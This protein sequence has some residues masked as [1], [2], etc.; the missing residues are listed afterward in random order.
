MSLTYSTYVT[1]IANLIPTPTSDANFQTVLPNVIDD[2][3]QRIYRE[4]DLL[5]TV[6]ADS[7]SQ[8][9]TGQRVFNLPSSIGTFVV[10]QR[11]N[12]ITPASATSANL[13]TR[14]PLT[15]C[16]PE[17]L[18]FFWPSSNGSTV[19]GYFAMVQQGMVI[20]G[21]WPDQAYTVEVVGTQRPVPL[22]ASNTTT[23]LTAYLPDLFLAASMVFVS[24]YMKNYGMGVDD[25]KQSVSWESHYQELVKSANVEEMRKKFN[26]AGWSPLQPAPMATPPRT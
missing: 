12:A 13:G 16:S 18:D 17:M 20:V 22:S 6:V 2:A 3:E 14:N 11:I 10:T 8:F 7:S 19:P 25:P 1:S 15:P 5:Q 9:T 4:L 24:G 23:F 21:P 26:Q